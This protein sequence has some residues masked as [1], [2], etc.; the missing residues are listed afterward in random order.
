MNTCL[1]ILTTLFQGNGQVL[2]S[3]E[4][5]PEDTDETGFTYQDLQYP[6]ISQ[7]TWD[8]D[9]VAVEPGSVG[10]TEFEHE[11]KEYIVT[12]ARTT[13]F[14]Q[15][16]YAVTTKTNIT[17]TIE[18]PIQFWYDASTTAYWVSTVVAI[19]VILLVIG[20]VYLV[21]IPLMKTIA[22]ARD[23]IIS[24]IMKMGGQDCVDHEVKR[25]DDP[26]QG[27]EMREFV[28]DSNEMPAV[29]EQS[30][31]E[32]EVDTIGGEWDDYENIPLAQVY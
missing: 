13:M 20:V 19:V 26:G 30:G 28:Q 5:N 11:G 22:A 14:D 2:A 27:I 1:L 6:P 24:E 25:I 12:T 7:E 23:N 16:F 9:V 10:T 31:E 17:S 4:W 32:P 21:A 29:F 8:D 15:Q 18:E 3:V